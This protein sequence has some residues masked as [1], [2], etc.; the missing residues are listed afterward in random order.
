MNGME[1]KARALFQDYSRRSNEAL[2]DPERADID[3]L[4]DAFA[5]HFVGANPAGVMGGAKDGSFPAIMRKGFETYRA[6]GGTRFEIVNLEVEELDGFN[7]MV[8]A[9]WEFDYVRPRDGAKGTI[10]FRN[11]YLVNFAGDRPAI[12]AWITPD[13]AQAMRDHGLV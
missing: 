9:D 1:A 2:H 12:F 3:A 10:A 8:R 11:I 5:G 7:A 6:T 4:A 13:E